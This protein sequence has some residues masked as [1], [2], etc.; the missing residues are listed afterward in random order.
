MLQHSD[1]SMERGFSY[2]LIA[3]AKWLAIDM[4]YNKVFVFA[5]CLPDKIDEVSCLESLDK[6]CDIILIMPQCKDNLQRS[7]EHIYKVALYVIL[8][9]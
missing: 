7:L 5:R 9:V 2:C 8:E 1:I 4:L 3:G 6:F